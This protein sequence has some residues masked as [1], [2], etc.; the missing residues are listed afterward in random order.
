MSDFVHS[1]IDLIL[2]AI[3]LVSVVPMIVELLRARSQR[4]D[5]RYDEL[6]EREQVLRE[7]VTGDE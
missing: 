3:V 7:K 6:A 2:I 1:N 5:P 4:R